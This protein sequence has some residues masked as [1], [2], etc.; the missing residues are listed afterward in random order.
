MN[1]GRHANVAYS[2]A[3]YRTQITNKEIDCVSDFVYIESNT[4]H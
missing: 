4:N 2:D 1:S 3:L